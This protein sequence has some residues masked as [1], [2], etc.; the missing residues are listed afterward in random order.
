MLSAK[1][2]GYIAGLL[3]GEGSLN[4]STTG[5]WRLC[6]S[7]VSNSNPLI[8]AKVETILDSWN[9]FYVTRQTHE[10]FWHVD[11]KGRVTNKRKFL[12]IIFDSLAGKKEQARLML[13]YMERRR[14]GRTSFITESDK[15]IALRVRQL[16]RLNRTG[17]VTTAR[18]S[19]HEIEEVK[20]QSELFGDEERSAE[21]TGPALVKKLA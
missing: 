9:I 15:A 16:N 1:D 7:A 12:E 10:H 18:E 14:D 19:F 5:G 13:K 4:F 6:I 11:I 21:M 8:I 17:S 20:I 3:D 2:I